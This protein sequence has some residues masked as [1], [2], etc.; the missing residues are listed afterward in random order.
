MNKVEEYRI[1]FYYSFDD[2]CYLATIPDLAG[3][4][5]DGKDIPEAIRNVRSLAKDWVDMT[6]DAG[7]DVP[8]PS[9]QTFPKGGEIGILDVAMYI[10]EQTGVI[11]TKALQK[12]LYYC[13]AWSCGWFDKALFPEMFEAWSGGPMNR[14]LYH[15]HSGSKMARPI[16][17]DNGKIKELSHE[18][19]EFVLEILG[20]YQDIDPD[21]LGSMTHVEEP[22]K[23]ARGSLPAGAKGEEVITEPNLKRYYGQVNNVL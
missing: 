19:K 16:M 18:Q 2:G 6:R 22:W 7:E 9:F 5:A 3:C 12:L 4:I 1:I 8:A 10:L 20:V 13:K 11:T 23:I 21:R 15:K 17:F 14:M